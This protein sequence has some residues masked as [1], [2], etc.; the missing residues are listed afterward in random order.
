MLSAQIGAALRE[1]PKAAVFSLRADD[2]DRRGRNRRRKLPSFRIEGN[3]D[4]V[5][6]GVTA[7]EHAMRC[8]VSLLLMDEPGRTLR[9]LMRGA[10]SGTEQARGARNQQLR[11]LARKT[12]GGAVHSAMA[13][14]LQAIEAAS[15][16]RRD[17]LQ[18][19][20]AEATL[21]R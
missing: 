11:L 17:G 13:T 6:G 4:C 10:A 1:L 8:Q 20:P 21:E 19:S 5:D 16:R 15:M 18:E 14:T 9:S 12:L 7:G 3:L 2:R